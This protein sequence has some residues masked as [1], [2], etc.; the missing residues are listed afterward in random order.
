MSSSIGSSRGGDNGGDGGGGKIAARPS[1]MARVGDN[2]NGDGGAG[3]RKN[4]IRISRSIVNDPVVMASLRRL[5]P[6][7][8]FV[9][10][11]CEEAAI[12]TA[13]AGAS[14]ASPSPSAAGAQNADGSNSNVNLSDL[15]PFVAS[16]LRDKVLHD[17][18]EE[19]RDLVREKE[20]ME[21]VLQR[22]DDNF[23]IQAV[24]GAGRV[25]GRGKLKDGTILGGTMFHVPLH[26]GGASD[27]ELPL[28]NGPIEF[29]LGD[30]RLF[31]LDLANHPQ[32]AIHRPGSSLV[33]YPADQSLVRTI[34]I[35]FRRIVDEPNVDSWLSSPQNGRDDIGAIQLGPE[36][37]AGYKFVLLTSF[38]RYEEPLRAILRALGVQPR[39]LGVQP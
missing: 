20:E 31:T 37:T 9:V 19:S 22:V 10:S 4:T 2:G 6:H 1:K 26:L 29:N 33:A 38:L 25:L 39:A 17:V 32:G 35:R 24:D 3:G 21:R 36:D 15:A 16:I 23:T 27:F 11:A 12:A 18:V 30:H 28:E 8:K 14:A 7:A 13:P 34:C 5:N